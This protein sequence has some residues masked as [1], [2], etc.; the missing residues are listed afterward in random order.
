MHNL[1]NTGR[2]SNKVPLVTTRLQ[3]VN[4]KI[5]AHISNFYATEKEYLGYIFARDDI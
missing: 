1:G 5:N 4:L 2:P 3:D